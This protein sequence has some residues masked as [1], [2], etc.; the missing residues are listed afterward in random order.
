MKKCLIIILFL[1]VID[2]SI[3]AQVAINNNGNTAASSAMLDIQSTEK[4]ILIP[5]LST[6]QRNAITDPANGLL[7]FDTWTESF[8]YY[9]DLHTE[10]Q[11]LGNSA[12]GATE[13]NELVDGAYDGSSIFFDS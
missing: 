6:D 2:N 4:G 13:I 10:W 5:R 1:A 8:W 12:S 7:V 11:Q 9:N 3:L